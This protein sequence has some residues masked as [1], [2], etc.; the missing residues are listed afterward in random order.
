[1][2]LPRGLLLIRP[3]APGWLQAAHI[4]PACVPLPLP[5][6]LGCCRVRVCS[7]RP[8]LQACPRG[9]WAGP[10]PGAM[11]CLTA[12]KIKKALAREISLDKSNT[13]MYISGNKDAEE[14]SL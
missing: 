8:L 9:I 11:M 3:A 10:G 14:R 2:G 1:M 5:L 7:D 12:E 4:D 6:A 13:S